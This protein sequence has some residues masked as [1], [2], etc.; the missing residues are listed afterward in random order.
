MMQRESVRAQARLLLPSSPPI[1]ALQ[2][3]LMLAPSFV[4]QDQRG[5]NILVMENFYPT[6]AAEGVADGTVVVAA[7]RSINLF[8]MP[9][10]RF[11]SGHTFFIQ[12]SGAARG[13][14]NVHVTFTE[15]ASLGCQ[16]SFPLPCIYM[17]LLPATLLDTLPAALLP[18]L[19]ALARHS[20]A[21]PEL[22]AES[23]HH[24][25]A[26]PTLRS[27]ASACSPSHARLLRRRRPRKALAAPGGWIVEPAPARVL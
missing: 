23:R 14:L 2:S 26:L 3:L 11:C 25:P 20:L 27:I 9:A 10:R 18:L 5:F 1:F 21:H 15:G 17:W 24:S 6:V 4:S 19:V 16:T 22:P 13:C 12:Q 7:N 8:P